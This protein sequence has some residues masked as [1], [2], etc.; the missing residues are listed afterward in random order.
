MKKQDMK[1]KYAFGRKVENYEE[2]LNISILGKENITFK[3]EKNQNK[4]KMKQ[5]QS[6][7]SPD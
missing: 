7:L 4:I 2:K 6:F 3:R 5:E 1:V